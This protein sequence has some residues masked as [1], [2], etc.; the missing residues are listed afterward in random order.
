MGRLHVRLLEAVNLPVT[1]LLGSAP[2][3]FATVEVGSSRFSTHVEAATSHPSWGEE[4]KF[5]VADADSD[6][7]VVRVMSK[8]TVTD[9]LLGDCAA[10]LSGLTRGVALR[11]TILLRN[12]RTC[13]ELRVEMLAADFGRE[14]DTAPVDCVVAQPVVGTVVAP[15]PASAP[16][17]VAVAATLGVA[18]A[19][20]AGAAAP[21]FFEQPQWAPGITQQPRHTIDEAK[22]MIGLP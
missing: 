6:R 22:R 14:P 7:V 3:A 11:S 13:A 10:T 20:A 18:A 15:A 8:G 12:C 1:G 5:D 16:V 9:E 4:F 2:D 21:W 19:P 17:A